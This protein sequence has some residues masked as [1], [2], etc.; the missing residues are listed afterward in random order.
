MNAAERCESC[1]GA[2]VQMQ[3]DA[4]AECQPGRALGR[5]VLGQVGQVCVYQHME[6][7]AVSFECMLR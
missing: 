3:R 6:T 7:R 1:A 4:R 2:T 5:P